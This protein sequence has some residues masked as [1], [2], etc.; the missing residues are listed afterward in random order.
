MQPDRNNPILWFAWYPVIVGNS[1]W[2]RWLTDVWA[3]RSGFTGKWLYNARFPGDLGS[4][5][6]KS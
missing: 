2:P 3:W 6:Q 4:T 1:P 5:Y